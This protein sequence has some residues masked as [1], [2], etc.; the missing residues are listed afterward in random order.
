MVGDCGGKNAVTCCI[1]TEP[2]THPGRHSSTA[3]QWHA[4][5]TRE[6][7]EILA[8][9]VWEE[10]VSCWETEPLLRIM[11]TVNTIL[12]QLVVLASCQSKSHKRYSQQL[13]VLSLV[14]IAFSYLAK[15]PF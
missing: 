15:K 6:T 9:A 12:Q 10:M 14:L 8:G 2:Y 13:L 3:T 5:A 4:H 7:K 11:S 1:E